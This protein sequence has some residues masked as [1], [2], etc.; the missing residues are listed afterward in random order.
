MSRTAK[1]TGSRSNLNLSCLSRQRLG[2][3]A[4]RS[5]IPAAQTFQLYDGTQHG[6]GRADEQ[7]PWRTGFA[8]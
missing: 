1:R 7:H 5:A 3:P 2:I 6:N 4:R 8:L